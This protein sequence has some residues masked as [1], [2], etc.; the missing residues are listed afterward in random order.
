MPAQVV[1][2]FVSILDGV[3]ESGRPKDRSTE[4]NHRKSMGESQCKAKKENQTR[5]K[6]ERKKGIE[7]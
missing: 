7:I 2:T 3:R 6:R 5:E 1:S 4:G